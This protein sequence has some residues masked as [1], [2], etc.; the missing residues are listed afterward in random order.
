MATAEKGR[1]GSRDGS[2]RPLLGTSQGK[3][4]TVVASDEDWNS[5]VAKASNAGISISE[6][7]R[8]KCLSPVLEDWE[9]PKKM[10]SKR[11]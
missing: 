5:I 4:R 10:R 6:F 8:R 3:N 9:I 11:H 7:V 1:G 2:G